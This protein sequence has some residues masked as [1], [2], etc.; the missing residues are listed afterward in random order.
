MIGYYLYN[1][2]KVFDKARDA[3]VVYLFNST[4]ACFFISFSWLGII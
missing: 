2:N 1:F 4:S 3:L